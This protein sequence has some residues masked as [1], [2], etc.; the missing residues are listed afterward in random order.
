[1]R[2]YLTILNAVMITREH[3]AKDEMEEAM[4]TLSKLE[5]A[6]RVLIKREGDKSN[7][8]AAKTS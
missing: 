1:M 3:I 8:L 6:L 5:T 7:E 2:R 4:L